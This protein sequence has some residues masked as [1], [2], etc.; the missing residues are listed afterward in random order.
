MWSAGVFSLNNVWK[1]L[2]KTLPWN[3]AGS[4]S[5]KLRK[6]SE[7]QLTDINL[8]TRMIT[9]LYMITEVTAREWR[10]L[11]QEQ[12]GSQLL[13]WVSTKNDNEVLNIGVYTNKTKNLTTLYT[14]DEKLNIIQASVNATHSLLVYVVKIIPEEDSDVKEPLYCPYLICLM[15]DKV[16]S[17]VKVEE[18]CTKQIMLQY[19]YG[20]SNKYSP[21]IRNDRFLLFKH[22]ECKFGFYVTIC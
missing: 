8:F 2:Y 6:V 9:T 11:G 7:H 5:R 3:F 1:W 21:G 16:Y 10:L 18:R 17:P 12:D 15:P 22:L 13:S 14:F 19:V 4:Y 20:K